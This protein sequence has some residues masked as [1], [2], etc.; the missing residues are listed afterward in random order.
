[1]TTPPTPSP[2]PRAPEETREDTPDVNPEAEAPSAER[3]PTEDSRPPSRVLR[4]VVL[5]AVQLC[6]VG[7][8]LGAF[9]SGAPT[10]IPVAL[11]GPPG[12]TLGATQQWAN[13]LGVLPG[14]PMSV[15][16]VA[17]RAEADRLIG[18]QRV[19][20]ALV[21]AD[22]GKQDE[23]VV[24]GAAGSDVLNSLVSVLNQVERQLHR[25]GTVTVVHPSAPDDPRG[26]TGFLLVV[27]WLAGAVTVGLLLGG[28]RL[29]GDRRGLAR[30]FGLLAG[31]AV[32]SAVLSV[33]LATGVFQALTG[34]M[35]LLS[36]V[37]V[38]VTVG[39][40]AVLL[41]ARTAGDALPVG[42]AL[43]LFGSIGLPSA[44]ALPAAV[45]LPPLWRGVGP[46]LPP[47]AGTDAVRGVAYFG[48]GGALTPI[49]VLVGYV[50]VGAALAVLASARGRARS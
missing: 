37:G 13:Q 44:G 6:F 46:W 2:T 16:A 11:V 22:P 36:L 31:Y 35:L 40:G 5:L 12:A 41:A 14:T 18:G 43:L 25:T 19:D 27:S 10:N 29:R 4:A 9:L 15:T 38:L 20:A 21:L 7:S 34:N 47:G 42:L 32:V 17:D 39:T 30:A 50:L 33:G 1:M 24:A 28:R 45:L 3:E 26:L 49:L 48:G 23:L 8:W